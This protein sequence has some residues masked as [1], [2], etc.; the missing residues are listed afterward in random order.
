MQWDGVMGVGMLVPT[1]WRSWLFYLCHVS[2]ACDCG[3]EQQ[4]ELCASP[5]EWKN[6]KFC[7][8]TV[9]LLFMRSYAPRINNNTNVVIKE[10]KAHLQD[11]LQNYKLGTCITVSPDPPLQR[12]G[13]ARLAMSRY[14]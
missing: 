7:S 8:F 6:S 4:E 1:C 2:R 12:G 9:C 13:N 3:F 14:G 11:L 5:I 10:R